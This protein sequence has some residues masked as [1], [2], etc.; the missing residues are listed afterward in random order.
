MPDDLD[1]VF[2][3]APKETTEAP[4][5]S[6][7]PTETLP[8]DAPKAEEA[9]PPKDTETAPVENKEIA[10]FKTAAIDE[11]RKRQAAQGETRALQTQLNNLTP[12]PDALE[13]PQ[14]AI[15]H[16]AQQFNTQLSNMGT[17]MSRQ[18]MLAVKDDY[19]DM[20]AK[21]MD[22]AEENPALVSQMVA[23]QNPAKFAYDTAKK[24]GEWEQVQDIDTYK[25]TIRAEVIADIKSGMTDEQL[26]KNEKEAKQS[27]V[28]L[29]SLANVGSSGSKV[30]TDESLE[31]MFDR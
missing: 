29:P 28:D 19:L 23:S 5:E 20:E 12:P 25:A 7:E 2:T 1:E 3:D 24:H 8:E 11:R 14:E 15:N 26:A 16:M 21:F 10:A 4:A 18:V 17:E 22:L 30:I 31:A 6:A 9:A 13:Q 27:G